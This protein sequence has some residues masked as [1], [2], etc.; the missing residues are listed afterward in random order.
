[1]WSNTKGQM[2]LKNER[3]NKQ[4]R[5]IDTFYAS[6]LNLTKYWIYFVTAFRNYWTVSWHRQH[7]SWQTKM[8][9]YWNSQRSSAF[10][11]LSIIC[12]RCVPMFVNCHLCI[13]VPSVAITCG[14]NARACCVRAGKTTLHIRGSLTVC[15]QDG[16]IAQPALAGR[17]RETRTCHQAGKYYYGS[18]TQIKTLFYSV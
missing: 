1:M 8:A 17:S 12:L 13:L 5:S 15:M 2:H 6:V 9:K 7:M 4:N 18:L 16:G 10:T 3:T 11:V 14:Y